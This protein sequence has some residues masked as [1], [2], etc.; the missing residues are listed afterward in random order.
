MMRKD[1]LTEI[2]DDLKIEAIENYPTYKLSS[3]EIGGIAK[4]AVFPKNSGEFCKILSFLKDE[5]EKFAVIGNC[6]N[7]FF[8]DCG[9]NGTVISTKFMNRIFVKDDTIT[10]DCGALISDCAVL[11]MNNHLSGIEFVC[12]IPGSVGG[13]IYMNASAF[14]D[15]VSKVVTKSTVFDQNSK[16]I[17]IMSAEEHDFNSKQSIF[18]KN[19]NLIVLST[20]FKLSKANKEE[21]KSTLEEIIKKRIRSQPLDIGNCGSTFKRPDGFFASK[22]IDEVGAKGMRVGG[23]T[24]SAKHAGF[25]VNSDNATAI[26]VLTLIEMIKTR[27]YD[28]FGISLEEEVIFLK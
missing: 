5:R 27:V 19:K 3:F 25:I 24:V 18:S 4:I 2:L 7:T 10:A 1:L 11:A 12:G 17:R 20:E 28:E 22:L 9:Y 15:S 13:A 26:D 16:E 14:G 23:A 8:D 21:I 6:T